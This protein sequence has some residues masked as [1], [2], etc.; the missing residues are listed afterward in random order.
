MLE[1]AVIESL[2]CAFVASS[3]LPIRADVKL[4]A[5]ER[6]SVFCITRPSAGIMYSPALSHCFYGD[7]ENALLIHL[8]LLN[9]RTFLGSN[10]RASLGPTNSSS[11]SAGVA[12]CTAAGSPGSSS[13][14]S[15]VSAQKISL[16][17]FFLEPVKLRMFCNFRPSSPESFDRLAFC[18]T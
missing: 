13:R 7:F 11:G 10:R 3:H 15:F 17:G 4:L 6:N 1:T 2:M 5:E 12:D 8:I 14:P 16:L 9:C 18:R